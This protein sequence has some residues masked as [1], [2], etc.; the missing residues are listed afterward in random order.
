MSSGPRRGA[1]GAPDVARLAHWS[2]IVNLI[3]LLFLCLLWE[4]LLAPLR[5]GGSWLMLKA[6]PLLL[7][8]FGILRERV[9]TYKWTMLLA[10]F[11]VAEGAV[12]AWSDSAPSSRLALAELLLAWI[13]FAACAIYVRN[14]RGTDAPRR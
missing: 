2:V 12:R 7:P 9:M 4:A 8:L 3:A 6:L 11:Y 13:L 10:L 14:A 5:P 1:G